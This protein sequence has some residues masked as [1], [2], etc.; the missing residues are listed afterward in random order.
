M[1]G[2]PLSGSFG[3]AFLSKKR[4]DANGKEYNDWIP[5]ILLE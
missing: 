3:K 4:F 5:S 1:T 2:F